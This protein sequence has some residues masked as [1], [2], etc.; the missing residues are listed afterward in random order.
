VRQTP[1]LQRNDILAEI[2]T[3]VPSDR[4]VEARTRALLLAP[5]TSSSAESAGSGD[6]SLP[7][8]DQVQVFG[9][10]QGTTAGKVEGLGVAGLHIGWP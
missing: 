2:T 6:L 5:P 4:S 7:A 3:I 1:Q 9:A 10:A 8:G